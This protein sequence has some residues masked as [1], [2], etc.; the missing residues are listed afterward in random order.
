MSGT[1]QDPQGIPAPLISVIIPTFNVEAYL[2]D[3]LASITQQDF[4]GIEII[5]VD[6]AS[7]DAT[8]KILEEAVGKEPRITAY[9]LGRIGP[10]M[11]R[12]E[13]VRHAKG[14][15]IWF[16]DGD[17]LICAGALNLIAD[18]LVTTQPDL[19]FIDYQASYPNGMI[20][21]GDGHHLMGR[22]TPEHFTL[23]DQPWVIDL[24]MVSWTKIIRRQF[25]LSTNVDFWADSPHEDIPVSCALLMEASRLSILN[26]VCYTYKKY[27]TGSA[28]GTGNPKR[29]FNIFH[30]YEV[31][32]DQAATKA[33]DGDQR[34]TE[35]VWHAFFQRA[36]WH[37]TSIFDAGGAGSEPFR[38]NRLIAPRDRRDFFSWMHQFY[39]NFAPPGYHRPPGFRGIKFALI[40]KNSYWTYRALAPAN[41]IRVTI[42][43]KIRSAR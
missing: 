43:R 1:L 35:A 42:C 37:Y 8:I 39:V 9:Y 18:R 12:N 2:P 27:R 19:L 38:S 32:V 40:E 41:K 24:N 4:Q 17:D 30:P 15:Y 10:G 31:V 14:Q 11:A 22:K 5:A 6:G 21:P 36:I 34:V 23:V 33:A 13:G 20:E 26:Q 28:M 3:C 16:V 29:H 25:Y 7:D